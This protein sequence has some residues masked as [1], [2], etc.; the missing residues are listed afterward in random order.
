MQKNEPPIVI[1]QKFD[2]PIET[3]WAA[4]TDLDR[5]RQWY[6]ENIPAFKAEVGFETRF[7]VNAGERVFPHCWKVT[8]VK[9]P[10]LIAYDWRYEGYPGDSRL[11]IE[12]FR[13]AVGTRL[14]LTHSVSESFPQD[15]PEFKRESGIAGWNYFIGTRLKEY[16]E[17]N[18]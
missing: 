3:V 7:E 1:E 14:K 17:K 6:F 2:N 18:R 15:I 8:A 13:Q 11:Q 9:P 12:L 16:L 4:I 5:M 10:E